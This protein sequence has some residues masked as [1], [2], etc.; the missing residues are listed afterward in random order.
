[1]VNMVRISDYVNL[2]QYLSIPIHYN[3]KY[4]NMLER[5]VIEN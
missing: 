1:M 2:L 4:L 3:V 5:Q